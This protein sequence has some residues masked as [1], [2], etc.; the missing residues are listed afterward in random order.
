M[1]PQRDFDRR[2]EIIAIAQGIVDSAIERQNRTLER[3]EALLDK[4]ADGAQAQLLSSILLHG[5][6]GMGLE[7]AI[8][9]LQRRMTGVEG[10]LEESLEVGDVRHSQN[11]I[12]L[13]RVEQNQH[14][15]KRWITALFQW[16]M[17]KD[18]E[19]TNFAKIIA[20]GTFLAGVL[21]YLS[22][23]I[24]SWTNV[25]MFLVKTGILLGK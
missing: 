25:K 22:H 17:K 2:N 5:D 24:P 8:P 9:N 12:R 7:G 18:G 14:R 4:I 19:K 13:E 1:E 21:H 23:F 6:V 15:L 11:L 10:K 3:F 16:A 20:L